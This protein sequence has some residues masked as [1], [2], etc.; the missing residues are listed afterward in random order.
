MRLRKGKKCIRC[1]KDKVKLVLGLDVGMD[2]V[3]GLMNHALVGRFIGKLVKGDS[4]K[5]WLEASWHKIMGYTPSIT[6][7]SKGGY[8]LNSKEQRMLL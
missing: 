7:W 6:S 8:A 2:R 3:E 1:R 4:L 5:L